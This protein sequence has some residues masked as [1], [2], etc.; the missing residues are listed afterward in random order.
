MRFGLPQAANSVKDWRSPLYVSPN[1]PEASG[2]YDPSLENDSC[3]AGFI[4]DIKGRKS[5]KI[6]EDAIATPCKLEHRGAVG[7]D[8]RAS[9][10][11]GILVQMPHRFFARK[12]DTACFDNALEF[13]VRGRHTRKS[14]DRPYPRRAGDV[15]CVLHRAAAESI[16]FEGL[17]RKKKRLEVRQ[18]SFTNECLKKV[19][20]ITC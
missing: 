8:P 18:P 9:D 2:M 17:T 3:G 4:A 6:V 13:L 7:A 20:S 1:L 5:H 11:A 12:S 15:A 10:G 19:C 14:S 16:G